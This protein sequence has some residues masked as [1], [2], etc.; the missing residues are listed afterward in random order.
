MAP[1]GTE[2]DR[3]GDLIRRLFDD[4][5]V[6]VLTG[7]GL[8]TASGIPDYRD[9]DGQWKRGKPID[10]RDFLRS[11]S[12]RKRYWAR[13]FVGWPT[14]GLANPSR[15]HHAL[16]QL[17]RLG[18]IALIITQNVDGL[19]QKA[20]SR[21][22]LE[23]HGGLERVICL[24]CHRTFPRAS[25]Q[26][27]MSEANP[28]FSADAALVGPDGDAQ[29]ADRLHADFRIPACPS[30]AGILKP[31][32]V[33]FG[34]SVPKDRV[35]AGMD[36]IAAARGLLIVGSSLMV[37]SGFRFADHAHRLGKPVMAI[38]RG[39]TRADCLLYAKV[40]EDCD[41]FLHILQVAGDR[42]G[43]EAGASI[44]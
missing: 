13:S 11:E 30:C 26:T 25:V 5:S 39:K 35:K 42:G 20:G 4:G 27:W 9:G 29:V 36:A 21:C 2:I 6:V 43:R 10:H 1:F 34:D 14:I 38:N 40:Q 28:V 8:S 24:D 16:A 22:V 19:H 31:D 33:F 44:R 18:R 23:L 32:V 17:E 7:A 41:E 15:G 3:A 37:Y 12:T